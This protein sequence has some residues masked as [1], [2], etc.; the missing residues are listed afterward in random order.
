MLRKPQNVNNSAANLPICLGSTV[1]MLARSIYEV[2]WGGT[3]GSERGMVERSRKRGKE[4]KRER[5]WMGGEKA[6]T[7]DTKKR[8]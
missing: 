3:R 5:E 8:A 2:T 7:K 1:P 6:R 4:G